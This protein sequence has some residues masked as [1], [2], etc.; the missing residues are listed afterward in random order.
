MNFLATLPVNPILPVNLLL[1]YGIFI[2]AL[3]I[4]VWPRLPMLSPQALLTPILLLH[5]MRELG[6]MFMFEGATLPGMPAGFAVP[7]AWGDLAAA[8]LAL[9]ALRAVRT[10]A[11]SARHW[12]WVFNLFGTADLINAIAMAITH[13][14]APHLGAAYWIPAFWVPMLLATH[15]VVFVYLWRH[16]RPATGPAQN[17]G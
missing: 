16:W 4:Y 7:A 1:G 2:T 12:V 13:Q 17:L 3:R 10:G 5:M 6:L 14:S 11:A 8:V 9:I 15:T